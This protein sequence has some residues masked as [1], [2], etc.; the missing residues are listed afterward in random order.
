MGPPFGAPTAL[1][2]QLVGTLAA[3]HDL[4]VRLAH[5]AAGEEEVGEKQPVSGGSF[6]SL[7]Q[8]AEKDGNRPE[9]GERMTFQLG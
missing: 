5:L 1:G 7:Q 6:C 8:P 3:A 2:A 4:V 9:W